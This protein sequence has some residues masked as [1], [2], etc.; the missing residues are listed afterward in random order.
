MRQLRTFGDNRTLSYCTFCGA[1]P[2]T[3]DHCPSKIF[4]DEPYPE[5]L[6]VVQS[7]LKCNNDFS[8]DEEYVACFLSCLVDA[9]TKPEKISR[10]KIQRILSEK[11]LLLKRIEKQ[12]KV[13]LA[14]VMQIEPESER[15]K[16]VI[17][18]LARGHALHEIHELCMQAPS[19]TRINTVNNFSSQEWHAFANPEALTLFPEVGSRAMQRLRVEDGTFFLDWIIAQKDTYSYYVSQNHAV[20]VRILLL[21]YL[22]CYVR[23]DY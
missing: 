5:N 18:K 20:E 16:R 23:W 2:E 4:L 3:K 7:C 8:I 10:S 22:A 19:E 6:P 13:L 9:T 1:I 14:G 21:N 12:S 15:L 11:P 17:V